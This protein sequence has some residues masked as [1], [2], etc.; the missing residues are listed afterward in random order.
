MSIKR[1]IIL[2]LAGVVIFTGLIFYFIIL[3]TIKDIQKINSDVLAERIDLEKK[4]Q[5]G[6]LLKKTIQ[7][8]ET[9]KPEEEKLDKIYVI[10][11][12]ELKFITALEN[13]AN[14]YNI[15]QDIGL[16]E[17]SSALAAGYSTLGLKITANGSFTDL[18]RY[19]KDIEKM[20]TYLNISN[21]SLATGDKNQ[22]NGLKITANLDGNIFVIKKLI[23]AVK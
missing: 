17:K 21:I 5:R 4:Y 16:A 19:L 23:T 8:F 1:K 3:P 18:L 14:K 15:A 6:Q 20:P 13:I 22:A 2:Y 12:E 10:E 11:G 7:N 9:I